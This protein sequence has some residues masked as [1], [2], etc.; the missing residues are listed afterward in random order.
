M[1]LTKFEFPKTEGVDIAF[2]TFETIPEL[3]SE[4]KEKKFYNGR[5]EYNSLFS[6]LFFNG[7]KVKF[8]QNIDNDFK[9]KA[10]SYCRAFMGSWSPKHE[11]KEA[12][13]ALIMSEL[14]EPGL[15]KSN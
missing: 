12:I 5:T 8:K 15:E 4:A 6:T 10:W 1:D 7:G 14:L 2:P 3:L 9:N 11:E 13:C